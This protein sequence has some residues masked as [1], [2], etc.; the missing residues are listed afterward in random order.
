M[1]ECAVIL[2]SW[3]C[4]FPTS[5]QNSLLPKTLLSFGAQT[6]PASLLGN[7]GM[8]EHGWVRDRRGAAISVEPSVPKPSLV[9]L[10]WKKAECLTTWIFSP[11]RDG[12]GSFLKGISKEEG[13]ALFAP[14]RGR[15]PLPGSG[16]ES[17]WISLGLRKGPI[18]F[19]LFRPQGRKTQD[20]GVSEDKI[21]LWHLSELW[22]LGTRHSSALPLPSASGCFLRPWDPRHSC[23]AGMLCLEPKKTIRDLQTYSTKKEKMQVCLL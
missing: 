8:Q 10:P 15:H 4:G 18:V 3:A 14:V 6:A 11:R 19:L 1:P 23:W 17:L 20:Q 9:A 21:S 5:P 22:L 2:A 7:S 13:S 16:G 12:R